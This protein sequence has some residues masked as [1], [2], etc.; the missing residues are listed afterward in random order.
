[1]GLCSFALQNRSYEALLRNLWVS[2]TKKKEY[3]L[4]WQRNNRDK[5]KIYNQRA[6][7]KKKLLNISFTYD[8]QLNNLIKG[9][10]GV[11][12]SLSTD[13]IVKEHT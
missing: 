1:M 7:D 9:G 8:I 4:Q 13:M 6:R 10:Q 2:D 12:S 11:E 5:V 3:G